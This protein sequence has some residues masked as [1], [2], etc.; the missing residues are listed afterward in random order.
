M[1]WHH[2]NDETHVI[3]RNVTR[4]VDVVRR[5]SIGTPY[6]AKVA[7]LTKEQSGE[8]FEVTYSIWRCGNCRALATCEQGVKP[9]G[10]CGKCGSR[11]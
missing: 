7:R 11:G 5:T 10:N 8:T 9:S 3:P 4:M 2:V 1:A 6:I